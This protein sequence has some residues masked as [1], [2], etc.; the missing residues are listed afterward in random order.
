MRELTYYV[1]TTIDGFVAGPDGDVGFFPVTPDVLAF[2]G[3]HFPETLPTAARAALGVDAPHRRFDTAI[4][5]RSTF[6]AALDAGITSPYEH[7]RQ[8]LA[9][10]TAEQPDPA[11]EVVADALAAVRELKAQ[12]GEGIW[13]VGGGS[14]AGALLPEIDRLVIKLYPVVVGE[15]VPL[16]RAGFSPQAFTLTSSTVLDG[17]T[18]VLEYER[19]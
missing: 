2:I 3:E 12:E 16:L 13:L 1:G 14:L 5:G 7:L 11:V 15:G 6:Q 4:Q 18:V 17:G 10:T 19:A 9:S 8:L